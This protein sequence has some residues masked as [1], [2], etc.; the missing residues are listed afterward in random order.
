MGINK[1]KPQSKLTETFLDDFEALLSFSSAAVP[2]NESFFP[3]ESGI[4][5]I[6]VSNWELSLW[7][8]HNK[9]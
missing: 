7:T 5:L 9:A 1:N 4:P 6:L 3:V 8:K 2:N